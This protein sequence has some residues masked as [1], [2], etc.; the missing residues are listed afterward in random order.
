MVKA[1]N[2]I[3]T[4]MMPPALTIIVLRIVS[5]PCD[6]AQSFNRPIAGS[7]HQRTS[8]PEERFERPTAVARAAG[9][10]TVKVVVHKLA[11]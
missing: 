8:T 10:T 6:V 3:E 9:S 1:I 2:T 11:W 7:T 5:P 4:P